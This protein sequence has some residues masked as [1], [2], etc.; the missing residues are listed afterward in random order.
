MDFVRREGCAGQGR[1]G[2]GRAGH[3]GD[4]WSLILFA[5]IFSSSMKGAG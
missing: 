2:A 4:D 3:A 5:L 1:G